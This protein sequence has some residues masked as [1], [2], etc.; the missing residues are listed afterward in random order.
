M[1]ATVIGVRLVAVALA[2]YAGLMWVGLSHIDDPVGVGRAS[3]F[4]EAILPLCVA[5]LTQIGLFL[6][7]TAELHGSKYRIAVGASMIP[8]VVMALYLGVGH[9]EEVAAYGLDFL[10]RVDALWM[11][12]LGLYVWQG[13]GLARRH[14]GLRDQPA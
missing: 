7:P 9:L 11:P 1:K 8:S 5:G 14:P 2:L 13:L 3:L 6:A 12:V 4:P 10:F